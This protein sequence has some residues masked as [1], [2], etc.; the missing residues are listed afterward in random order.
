MP[1]TPIARLGPAALACCAG[2]LFMQFLMS[3][4]QPDVQEV[5]PTL[6]ASFVL[7]RQTSERVVRAVA[8]E[9]L[10][11]LTGVGRP[12]SIKA[13]Q[14]GDVLVLDLNGKVV[15]RFDR[16][17]SP[18]TLYEWNDSA[19]GHSLFGAPT[20]FDTGPNNEVWVAD[21]AKLGIIVFDRQGTFLRT[22]PLEVPVSHLT[23][24]RNDVFASVPAR[25]TQHLVEIRNVTHG[26]PLHMIGRFLTDWQRD[27]VSLSGALARDINGTLAV[28]GGNYAGMMVAVDADGTIRYMVDTVD[29]RPVPQIQITPKGAH[30]VPTKTVPAML[31]LSISGQKIFVV[32]PV[33]DRP[34]PVV[35]VY[36]ARDG[37][38]EFSFDLPEKAT[39]AFVAGDRL[40]TT[41]R[42]SVIAWSFPLVS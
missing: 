12:A 7:R 35:D 42:N 1:M 14:E 8:I 40:Y 16:D 36:G 17:G 10:F 21:P 32:A 15:R 13:T 23:H 2:V 19:T 27:S 20:D 3:A 9:R 24:F 33:P 29:H 4:M 25:V 39:R 38:Y 11:T 31:S 30:R 6:D 41:T 28:Y 34:V 18:T 22:M 26:N 37:Q 5:Q